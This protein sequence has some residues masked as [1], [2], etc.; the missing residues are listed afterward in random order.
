MTHEN[1]KILISAYLDGETT[2]S[3]K[4]QVEE[5]LSSCA[6]CQKEYQTYKAMSNSLSKWSN[7]RLSPD[8]EIKIHN[9][10]QRR[11]EP[12]FTKRN[13]MALGTTL[14]LTIMIGSVVQQ[15]TSKS[16]FVGR[17][18]ASTAATVARSSLI[19]TKE[20]E[21][22]YKSET[23][24]LKGEASTYAPAMAKAQVFDAVQPESASNQAMDAVQR[25][26]MAKVQ[27]LFL[28][29][30]RQ[31]NRGAAAVAL[32]SAN[33]YY[34]GNGAGTSY[35]GG[36]AAYYDVDEQDRKKI[37]RAGLSLQVEN[38]FKTKSQLTEL[39]TQLNA[40]IV[41]SQFNRSPDGPGYGVMVCKVYPK[42]LEPALQQIRK[43]GE[44]ENENQS[45]MDVT[46]QY[47]DAHKNMAQYR[48]DKERLE[49][50]LN[51]FKL[52][53]PTTD[54]EKQN[55]QQQIEHTQEQLKALERVIHF[56]QEQTQMSLVTIDYHDNYKTVVKD[57]EVTVQW[58]ERLADKWKTTV[59]ASVDVF[60]NI[61]FS[62][63]VLLSYVAPIL[64]WVIV[65]II[66]FS[67]VR[68]F[69]RK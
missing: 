50:S 32:K 31:Q 45:L 7:E 8:E 11:R 3:E 43:L 49:K 15:Y 22:Y 21:P 56:Y 33:N 37:Q 68:L 30:A 28:N 64:I 39:M 17:K 54:A 41:S 44:V 51:N 29:A 5:H 18:D 58:K 67:I 47:A 65:F 23:L 35:A 57:K 6:E 2:P 20:Y 60:T 38:A 4:I 48:S 13:L 66:L 24:A 62:S 61:L 14:A 25:K 12:M 46:D 19:S 1:I 9:H 27:A 16:Y 59:D 40:I 10:L 34:Q 69:F 36:V 55:I 52:F 63:L 42:D 53:N 26:N